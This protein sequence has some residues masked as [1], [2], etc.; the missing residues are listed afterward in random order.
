[1]NSLPWPAVLGFGLGWGIAIGVL[2]CRVIARIIFIKPMLRMIEG[3]GW[4]MKSE[5]KRVPP[6]K[7][8]RLVSLPGNDW[9]EFIIGIIQGFAL[10]AGWTAVICT[11]FWLFGG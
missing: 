2:I 11:I 7:N 1:M 3:G 6:P 10:V 4:R 9:R 8:P 5:P